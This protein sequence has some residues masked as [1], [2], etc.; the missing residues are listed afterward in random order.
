VRRKRRAG[1]L[2]LLLLL[3]LKLKGISKGVSQSLMIY[4]KD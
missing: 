3:A 1:S 4:R 2:F